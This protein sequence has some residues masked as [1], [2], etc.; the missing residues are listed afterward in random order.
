MN[1]HLTQEDVDSIIEEYLHQDLAQLKMLQM[2]YM[3]LLIQAPM[4]Q[5]KLLPLTADGRY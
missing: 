3:V 4:L 1:G 2:L 5:D